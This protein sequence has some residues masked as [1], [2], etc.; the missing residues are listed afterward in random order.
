MIYFDRLNKR[1][2]LRHHHGDD[3]RTVVECEDFNF[4]VLLRFDSSLNVLNGN[5][6][7]IGR[8][9]AARND[10]W[11][12]VKNDNTEIE[13]NI[14]CRNYHWEEVLRAEVAIAKVLL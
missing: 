12:L 8:L 2:H 13:L 11:M 9:S 6:D 5:G 4:K 1:Y 7:R 10:E 3:S 14:P